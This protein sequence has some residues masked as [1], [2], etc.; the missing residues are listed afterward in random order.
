M[1][2]FIILRF[3]IDIAIIVHNFYSS[4][5]IPLDNDLLKRI[6]RILDII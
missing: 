5:K 2:S 3:A 4:E 1:S 6:Q